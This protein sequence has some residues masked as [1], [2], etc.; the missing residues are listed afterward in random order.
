MFSTRIYIRIILQVILIL[1]VAGAGIAGIL[2]GKAIILGIV[3]LFIALWQ[4][5]VLVYYLNV[6]NRRIQLFLDAIED[7]ESMLYFPENTGSEEQRRLHAAFN[8]IHKL[9][10]ESKQK[11]FDRELL[12]KEYEAYDKLMHVLTHEIMN[13]IAPIV[14]LSGT[15]LS[16]FQSKG[17][18]KGVDELS[19][20][21]IRKTIRGLD[22]IKSQG[23]SLINFTNSYRQLARLQP[24][25]LK[26]LSLAHLIRNIEMLFHA[27]LQRLGIELSVHLYR[28]EILIDADEELL[29]QVLINLLKNAMQALEG[30][31]NGCISLEV[32]QAGRNLIIEVTDNGPG[33]PHEILDDIFVPFF[34]TKGSG[35]GIGLSL[36][37]Q[38]I[39]M[40]EGELSVSSQPY[41]ATRFSITLPLSPGNHHA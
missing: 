16:Y 1:V 13:S 26:Q 38:I 27:D 20:A 7:N 37:R 33:I 8:R 40:H 14:S 11:E 36:S 28:E 12:Q 25:K 2:S 10:T 32:K 19:D 18:A 24:P 30:Q 5:G 21:T 4:V 3:A 17:T 39:R 31:E 35:S 23:Q 34:T 41:T 15:L 6:S 22:T 29:S 9:M